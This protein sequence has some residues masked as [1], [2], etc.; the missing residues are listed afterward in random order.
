MNGIKAGLLFVGICAS[1]AGSVYYWQKAKK[2]EA[3]RI[4][5][6]ETRLLFREYFAKSAKYRELLQDQADA[7]GT[8][9]DYRQFM[10]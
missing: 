4:E 10:N 2:E 1:G 3:D 5:R 6:E 8:D 9:R 7:I